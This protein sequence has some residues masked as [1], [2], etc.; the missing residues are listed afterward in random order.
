LNRPSVSEEEQA[1]KTPG[2]VFVSGFCAPEKRRLIVVAGVLASAMGFIDGT[3]VPIAIPAIRADIGAS[4][5]EATW[6]NNAYMVVL[7]ALILAGGAFGDRFG[8][9]RMFTAGIWLFMA[10]SLICAI[11]PSP[12]LLIIAR[13]AQGLG[14]A[15]MVPGSLAIISRAH[16]RELR[17]HAI[18]TWAAAAAVTTALGPVIAGIALAVGGDSMWRW[19]FAINIPFGLVA[20]WL[21]RRGVREDAAR[22]GEPID[23]RGGVLATLALGT[24]AWALTHS[25][26]GQSGPLLWAGYVAGAALLALFLL[27][28]HRTA[29]PMLPLS[30]FRNPAFSASNFVTFALY[31]GLSAIL[32]F[33]PMLVIAGWGIPEIFAAVALA[34]LSFFVMLLSRKFA[35]TAQRIGHG[36]VIGMGAIVVAVAYYWL[37]Q[38]V[39]TRLFWAGVLPPMTLGGLGMAMVVAPLS[40][41][42]M[43]SVEDHQTGAASGVNNAV[44]RIAGLI[45]VAAM[46]AVV[47][48]AYATAGGPASYGIAHPGEAHDVAMVAAFAS[49]AQ[50]SAILSVVAAIAAFAAVRSPPRT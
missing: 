9:A 26:Q 35:R 47:S 36:N 41:V 44:S 39:E 48:R 13:F 7:S 29:H 5:G 25:E 12:E 40:T 20:I 8:L 33:L 43:G 38:A 18:G 10:T 32:F 46:S 17:G 23:I 28:E 4:L 19:I 2:P 14:A 6:I 45:A 22:H 31:F 11:A 1:P 34:P 21:V 49:V 3:V 24:L 37:G 42:V 50:V 16:P 27:H 30:L 15:L